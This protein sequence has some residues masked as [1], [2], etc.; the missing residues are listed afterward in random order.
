MNIREHLEK[1]GLIDNKYTLAA[2]HKQKIAD[3]VRKN[4]EKRRQNKLNGR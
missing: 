1:E 3:G 4:W 2:Q